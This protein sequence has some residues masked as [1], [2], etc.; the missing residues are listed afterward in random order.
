[1]TL[2]EAWG[3][4]AREPGADEVQCCALRCGAGTGHCTNQDERWGSPGLSWGGRNRTSASAL[5]LNLVQIRSR[6]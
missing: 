2:A 1:M 4:L 6:R 3:R 5:G